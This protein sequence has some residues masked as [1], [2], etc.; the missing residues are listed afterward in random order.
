[1]WET[2]G[3]RV[4]CPCF[5]QLIPLD[6]AR[7][8]NKEEM[9]VM[10]C[11]FQRHVSVCLVPPVRAVGC[12]SAAISPVLCGVKWR[13]VAVDRGG[14]LK[15]PCQRLA[16]NGDPLIRQ[17]SLPFRST[18]ILLW[19][20]ELRVRGEGKREGFTVFVANRKENGFRNI[21]TTDLMTG[22]DK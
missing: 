19:E 2:Y 4:C 6:L 12:S 14:Q 17:A 7:L 9:R 5:H 10:T 16:S 8:T 3:A 21:S 1:M 15:S 22:R 11:I 18:C 13:S 20:V